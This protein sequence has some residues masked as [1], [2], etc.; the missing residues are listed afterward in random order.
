MDGFGLYYQQADD[1]I[2]SG[3]KKT[4]ENSV[5]EVFRWRIPPFYLRAKVEDPISYP[6]ENNTTV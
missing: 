6:S 4:S 2:V 5:P 3:K 1:G